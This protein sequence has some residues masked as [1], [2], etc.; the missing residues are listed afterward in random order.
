MHRIAFIFILMTNTNTDTN[1][2]MKPN[3]NI[4]TQIRNRVVIPTLAGAIIVGAAAAV[5]AEDSSKPAKAEHAEDQQREQDHD[6]EEELNA[7]AGRL[8]ELSIE[9]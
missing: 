9:I 6:K 2:N 7:F 3:T 4:S 1:K 8:F 5:W